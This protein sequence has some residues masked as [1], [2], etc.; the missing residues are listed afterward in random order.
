MRNTYYIISK[1][2]DKN[3]TILKT[4]RAFEVKQKTFFIILMG[5][6]LYYNC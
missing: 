4:K 5:L 2:Q 3:I 1:A 6:Q